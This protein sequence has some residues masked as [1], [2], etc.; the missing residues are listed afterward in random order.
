MTATD[1]NAW[2]RPYYEAGHG[3]ALLV[4]VVF[5]TLNTE[6]PFSLSKYRVNAV[7]QDVVPTRRPIE[8]ST[9]WFDVAPFAKDPAVVAAAKASSECIV[10][11]G[12]VADPPD[13][14][15]LRDTVGTVQ[16][17]LDN[18]G[19]AVLDPQTFNWL[20]AADF[21]S[22]FFASGKPEVTQ[23]VDIL[24]SKEPG[25][26]TAWYHTRGLRK[27]GRP[28]LS[29]RGVTEAMQKDAEEALNRFIYFQQL[30]GFIREGVELNLRTMTGYVAK[31]GGSLDDP[32]FNNVH[33]E[34]V[35][36]STK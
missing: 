25:E 27:F 26:A 30:G 11:M 29:V 18:G 32:D 28:D 16:W 2:G 4:Y 19:V 9:G 17:L 7:R 34:L 36:P 5:G 15:Y 10:L 14:G 20:S 23:H 3:D 21:T 33:V 12:T 35:K 22:T 24:V 1:T 13:L 6:A 31:H 8:Q